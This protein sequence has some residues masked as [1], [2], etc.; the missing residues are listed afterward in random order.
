[1]PPGQ[2][3]RLL[4]AAAGGGAEPKGHRQADLGQG[5]R[6]EERSAELH[7]R[8]ILPGRGQAVQGHRQPQGQGHGNAGGEDQEAGKDEASAGHRARGG[9]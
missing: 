7:R 9:S 1:M 2:G 5:Q 6:G 4:R 8:D 3:I